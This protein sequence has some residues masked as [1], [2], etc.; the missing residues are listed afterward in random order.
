NS[1]VEAGVDDLVVTLDPDSPRVA[2]VRHT[3]GRAW[4][5]EAGTR[6]LPPRSQS[7][8]KPPGD[9]SAWVVESFTEL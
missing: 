1:G 4:R 6:P 9:A 5:V 2:V 7:C 3:D 8:R